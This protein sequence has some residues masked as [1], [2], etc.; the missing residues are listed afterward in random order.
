MD[1]HEQNKAGELLK[2]MTMVFALGVVALLGA[3]ILSD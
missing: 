1:T 3:D 2:D